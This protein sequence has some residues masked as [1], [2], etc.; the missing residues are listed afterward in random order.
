MQKKLRGKHSID[1]D[2]QVLKWQQKMRR[3]G[4]AIGKNMRKQKARAEEA[5]LIRETDTDEKLKRRKWF[6]EE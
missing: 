4:L 5:K 3:E 2:P 6:G 1:V